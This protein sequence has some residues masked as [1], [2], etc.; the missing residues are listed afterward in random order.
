MNMFSAA[1]AQFGG[2]DGNVHRHVLVR[3]EHMQDRVVQQIA[4]HPGVVFYTF[5]SRQASQRFLSQ[6]AALKN[7]QI[8]A[9]DVMAAPTLALENF[10]GR[11][12]ADHV[13]DLETDEIS[14]QQEEAVSFF[15]RHDDGR[16][17]ADPKYRGEL[18][19]QSDVVVMSISRASKTPTCLAMA[20]S[21]PRPLKAANIPLTYVVTELHGEYEVS[22][23]S[24]AYFEAI[25]AARRESTRPYWVGLVVSPKIVAEHRANR[26]KRGSGAELG[27]RQLYDNLFAVEA[28][29]KAAQRFFGRLGIDTIQTTGLSVEEIAG[30]IIGRAEKHR[31]KQFDAV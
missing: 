22:P 26:I 17:V 14:A 11:P 15:H 20:H 16:T 5:G 25:A 19:H 27:T 18:I 13:G 23:S 12:P 28:E 3:S 8:I 24:E 30:L 29:M 21:R 7:Q 31:A 6:I 10:F 4:E 9:L 2:Y 1:V